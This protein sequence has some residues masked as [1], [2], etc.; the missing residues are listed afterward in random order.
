MMSLRQVV[1]ELDQAGQT[2]LYQQL[3]RGLRQAI[4]LRRL[5]ADEFLPPERDIAE[6]FQISRFTVRKALTALVAEGRLVRRQGAGNCVAPPAAG[7]VE[8]SFSRLISLSEE[9]RAKGRSSRCIW[10][11]RTSGT[12]TPEEATALGIAPGSVVHRLDRIRQID[13]A[14]LIVEF[15]TSSGAAR[16][17]RSGYICCRS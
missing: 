12:A 6:E 9:L 3:A 5:A 2:P 4:D 1:G 11:S 13:S 17:S 10:L 8:T 15:T 16:L 14:P 7:R